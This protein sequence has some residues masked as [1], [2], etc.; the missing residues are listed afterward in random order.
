MRLVKNYNAGV[1]PLQH[2][3]YTTHMQEGLALKELQ[4]LVS[5]CTG[6]VLY[7]PTKGE[8][9]YNDP[10]FPLEIS[11]DNLIIPKDKN[12]DPFKWADNCIVKFKNDSVYVL[13]PGTRFDIYGTR[14]GRGA[15][16][17]DRF[18]SKVPSSWLRIGIA[19]S[20][21]FSQSKL[22]RQKWDKPVDWIII[23]DNFSWIVQKAQIYL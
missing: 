13:I 11:K 7:I 1:S 12:S 4:K 16:W 5:L 18:L 21:K 23:Q 10:L 6:A 3:L 15:G 19:D 14:H 9:N 2:F 17:Y 8:V 22:I 20:T